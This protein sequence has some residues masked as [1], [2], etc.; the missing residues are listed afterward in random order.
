MCVWIGVWDKGWFGR[1]QCAQDV[2]HARL[3][4]DKVQGSWEEACAG[5]EPR[6]YY[7]IQGAIFKFFG[8]NQRETSCRRAG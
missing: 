1:G 6:V 4:Y 3:C 7:I 2:E 8:V 5:E